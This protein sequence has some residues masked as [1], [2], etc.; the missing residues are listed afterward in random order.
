MGVKYL[1]Y[2]EQGVNKK[3]PSKYVMEYSNPTSWPY[4]RNAFT[5]YQKNISNDGDKSNDLLGMGYASAEHVFVQFLGAMTPKKEDPKKD[6]YYPL[7]TPIH[8]PFIK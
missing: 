7:R 4:M 2:Y 3:I 1:E 6:D 8:V 5:K